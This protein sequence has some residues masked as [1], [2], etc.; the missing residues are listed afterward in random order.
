ME[1]NLPTPIYSLLLEGVYIYIFIYIHC[2]YYLVYWLIISPKYQPIR[3]HM[4]KPVG[5]P[6]RSEVFC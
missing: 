5:L 4:L 1:T 3:S 6:W 2:N